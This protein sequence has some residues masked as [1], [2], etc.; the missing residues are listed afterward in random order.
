[1]ALYSLS[2]SGMASPVH[3]QQCCQCTGMARA[4]LYGS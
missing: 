2:A 3:Q 1:L 4:R